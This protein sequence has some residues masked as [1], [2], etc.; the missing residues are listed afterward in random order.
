MGSN[1]TVIIGTE[2]HDNDEP[3]EPT[4]PGEEDNPDNPG[5][6][7]DPDNPDN[8]GTPDDPGI[9][10]GPKPGTSIPA[11]FD[12]LGGSAGMILASLLG[13]FGCIAAAIGVGL[14]VSA[15]RG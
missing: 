12:V 9:P 2:G 7:G 10:V 8:P 11:T 14:R 5:E 13:T 15:R 6:P 1:G 4:I 3:N